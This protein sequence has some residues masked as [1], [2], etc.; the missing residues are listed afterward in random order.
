L[1]HGAVAW[2][3]GKIANVRTKKVSYA[4]S[5]RHQRWLV[6]RSPER[7]SRCDRALQWRD[8][9]VPNAAGAA[10]E[11]LEWKGSH[12]GITISPMENF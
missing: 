2:S 5:M 8:P 4:R 7:I 3:A 11:R 12:L 9:L 10:P 6:W 1:A